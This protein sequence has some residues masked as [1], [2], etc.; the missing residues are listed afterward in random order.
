MYHII[1]LTTNIVN[2]KIYVGV[3]STNNLNDGYLGS[4]KAL[5]HSIRKYGKENFKRTILY[6]CLSEEE[7]L[8]WESI[9][10]DENF[11]SRKNVYNIKYGGG[12]KVPHT[13]EIKLKMSL[14]QKG[15]IF[16]E[17]RKILYSIRMKNNNPFKDKTHSEE[18]KQIL[19]TKSKDRM[20]Q[21]TPEEIVNMIEHIATFNRGKKRSKEFCESISAHRKN[22]FPPKAVK[23]LIMD[24]NLN[25]YIVHGNLTNFS[26]EHNLSISLL[27]RFIDKGCIIGK[28][29]KQSIQVKNTIGWSIQRL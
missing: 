10:V 11:L 14:K 15:R 19:A 17:E 28:Q 3:H 29:H 18:T 24:I 1:Y 8:Q 20:N 4:G 27:K 7:S 21:K 2:N 22:Q 12:N 26:K 5:K 23:Y 6:Y 13:E 9:I 25:E 16:P